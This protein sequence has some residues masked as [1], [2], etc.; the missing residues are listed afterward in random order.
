MSWLQDKITQVMDSL[1]VRRLPKV[2]PDDVP[3]IDLYQDGYD[4]GYKKGFED[5]K[6]SVSKSDDLDGIPPPIE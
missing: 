2:Y 5:G 6:M 4:D 1:T 3:I